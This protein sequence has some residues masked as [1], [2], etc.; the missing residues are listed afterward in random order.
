MKRP[1]TCSVDEHGHVQEQ[2]WIK[3]GRDIL[4]LSQLSQPSLACPVFVPT[5]LPNM[6]TTYT[7]SKQIADMLA[8]GTTSFN[9]QIPSRDDLACDV[10]ILHPSPVRNLAHVVQ[11]FIAGSGPIGSTYARLLV[12]AGY[13]V[14][15]SF[16][17]QLAVRDRNPR[18]LCASS[19]RRTASGRRLAPTALCRRR[20]SDELLT[21]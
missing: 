4:C 1:L 3:S 18:L 2:R 7:S 8:K 14:R 9:P 12:E 6:P 11:V 10:L 17:L 13:R 16:Q 20:S 15:Y 19:A 5:T 21:V